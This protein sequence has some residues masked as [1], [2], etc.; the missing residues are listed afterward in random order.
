[1]PEAVRYRNKGTRSGTEML[2]NRTEIPDAAMPM[3]MPTLRLSPTPASFSKFFF[4]FENKLK[5]DTSWGLLLPLSRSLLLVLLLVLMLLL[6]LVLLLIL[7][8]DL[9]A[10][11]SDKDCSFR[12]STQNCPKKLRKHSSSCRK[13]YLFAESQAHCTVYDVQFFSFWERIHF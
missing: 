2:R 6:V 4:F 1:M 9:S 3:P 7:F 8:F 12:S 13:D 5:K 10:S 11:L